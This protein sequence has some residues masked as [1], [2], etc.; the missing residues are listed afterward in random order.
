M[1]LDTLE[2][3]FFVSTAK[4]RSV[5]NLLGAAHQLAVGSRVHVR[6]HSA[7]IKEKLSSMA[8]ALVP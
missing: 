3:H 5:L 7:P 2:G 8:M 6:M 4:R 1:L